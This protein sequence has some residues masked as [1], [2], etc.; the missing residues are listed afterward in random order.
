M[1][2]R[3]ER[4]VS[5]GSD[6][7][8]DYV[9]TGIGHSAVDVGKMHIVECSSIEEYE[10]GCTVHEGCSGHLV[11]TP[12]GVLLPSYRLAIH[13]ADIANDIFLAARTAF[14]NKDSYHANQA[15]QILA[16]S[17]KGKEGRMRKGVLNA[18]IDGSL[19]MVITPQVH[20]DYHVVVLPSYIRGKWR[21]VRLDSKTQRYVDKAVDNWDWA[22][23]E[24]PP[25]L[26][27]RSCQP[28]RV[29]FANT[30]C[31][32]ISPYLVKAFDGDF[33]GDEMH[34]FP[35]YD[36]ESVKECEAWRGTP[37]RDFDTAQLILDNI[38]PT[39]PFMPSPRL[40]FI[41]R[42]TLAFSE[43]RD[44]GY[45]LLL[46]DYAKMKASH[47]DEMRA[48]FDTRRTLSNFDDESI[49]GM[50]DTNR[51]MLSQSTVGDM[52]RIAKIAASCLIHEDSGDIVV[53]TSTGL[54]TIGVYPRDGQAGARAQFVMSAIC[55]RGQQTYLD[56]HKAR[57][58]NFSS[59]NL[60]EDMVVGEGRT[61][62]VLDPSAELSLRKLRREGTWFAKAGGKVFAVV[63]PGW[64]VANVGEGYI[65][66][67]YNPVVL[68]SVHPSRRTQV[69]ETAVGHLM[70]YYGIECSS[71]DLRLVSELYCYRV[72]ASEHPITTR[73]GI[74][75]RN[76]QWVDTVMANHAGIAS[77]MEE[78]GE[79][80]ISTIKTVSSALVA[81]NF[82]EM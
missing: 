47:I 75:A 29:V 10:R 27:P 52:S 79:T 78:R 38:E 60:I 62:V 14:M 19:R 43:I 40:E 81:S 72:E 71:A 12:S 63:R 24:R 36:E 31:M 69:C 20:L 15:R 35:V 54:R 56:A 1:S 34:L 58:S 74:L 22:I 80:G 28:V 66:G 61:F 46:G 53:A 39:S 42:T 2:F 44:G 45:S 51:R 59:H 76:L 73:P 6:P 11:R 32:E 82:E 25:A 77:R 17:L 37:N 30:S 18:C 68:S 49:K 70:G 57:E 50:E 9:I 21:V 55:A 7:Q 64:V 3:T 16:S 33:D 41:E 67:S 65:V 4:L 8:H 23:A 5:D 26:S 13:T 48:R